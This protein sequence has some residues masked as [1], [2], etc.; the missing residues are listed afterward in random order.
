[1]DNDAKQ[2]AIVAIIKTIEWPNWSAILPNKIVM[3]TSTIENS[4]M[5]KPTS[6]TSVIWRVIWDEITIWI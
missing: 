6:F 4:A 3:R 1:M 2:Q 5:A